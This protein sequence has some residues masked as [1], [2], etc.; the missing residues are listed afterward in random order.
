MAENARQIIDKLAELKP[1]RSRHEDVWKSCYDMTFPLRADGINSSVDAVQG[2][3]KQ[4]ELLDD[5]ATESSLVLAANIMNGLTPSNVRWFGQQVIGESDEDKRWLET[6]S[7]V[8]WREIHASNF[9][10]AGYECAVDIVAAGWFA[11]YVDEDR[12]RQSYNFEQWPIGQ[13][14]CASSKSGGRVDIVYR[15]YQL[16]AQQAVTK[17]GADAVSAKTAKLAETKPNEK[18]SFVHAIYPRT[19]HAVNARLAKSLPFASCQVEV[20]AKHIVR[21]SGYHEFPVIVPRWMMIPNSVYGVGPVFG[22]LPTIRELNYL[23]Y[24]HRCQAEIEVAPPTLV[25]SDG[26]INPRTVKLG[27]RKLI[28]VND[29]ERSIRQLPT[30]GNWQLAMEMIAQMQAAI[31]KHLMADVLQ[32]QDGPAMTA[33]EVHARMALVRQMLG[34]MYGRFQAEY[35]QPLVERCFGIAYRA[36]WLGQ[37]PQSLAGK[38]FTVKYLSPMARSQM[39][40]EVSA[41]QQYMG[42]VMQAAQIKPEAIDSL[43]IDEALAHVGRGLGVPATIIPTS[44]DLQEYREAK[45]QA[46]EQIEQQQSQSQMQGMAAQAVAD[47]YAK[48]GLR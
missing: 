3:S 7:T 24:L 41:I 42:V 25:S 47:R 28:V 36:G 19:T 26:V 14:Y 16:T 48:G 15:E 46:Q 33:T 29:V 34:P 31:R 12:E 5:T 20:D 8:I 44:E 27:A 45:A 32:P 35:L 23:K 10:A 4:A 21:E 6:A 11:L 37:A 18:I 43:D 13:L 9:D 38:S 1:L 22:V 30:A 40:E 2:Q 39:A 17:F